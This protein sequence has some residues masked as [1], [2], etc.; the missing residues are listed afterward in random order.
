MTM[1]DG[2]WSNSGRH[3]GPPRQCSVSEC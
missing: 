1:S 3:S 2:C